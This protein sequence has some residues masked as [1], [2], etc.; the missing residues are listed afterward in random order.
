MNHRIVFMG[1]P[2][3][4]VTILEAL[5]RSPYEVV[6][7]VTQPDKPKGRKK[8][9]TPPPVKEAA[10]RFGIPV[11]Q[12][13]KIRRPEAVEAVL[14]WRPDL[15]VTA[16]YGQL[17][18]PALLQAPRFGCVNVHASLLPKYRGGAPTPGASIRGEKET[19]ITLMY[20]TEE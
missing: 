20:M 18:P 8:V 1:T 7:V 15:I 5:V 10:Q 4:A 3:F 2:D 14:A 9:L 16:A 19:G 12:P 6:G 11:L 17:V 13:E